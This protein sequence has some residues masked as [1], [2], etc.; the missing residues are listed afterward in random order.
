MEA[1]IAGITNANADRISNFIMIE[2]SL[3][4]IFRKFYSNLTRL[5]LYLK[6]E[7]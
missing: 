5:L 1:S 2:T 7:Y 6:H 3:I 4:T